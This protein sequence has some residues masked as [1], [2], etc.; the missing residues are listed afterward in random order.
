MG[1]VKLWKRPA[2]GKFAGEAQYPENPGKEGA[3]PQ[4]LL[5][6]FSAASLQRCMC[7]TRESVKHQPS[8]QV[9][10]EACALREG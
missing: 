6:T 3:E 8:R 1:L 9:L 2:C 4:P 7:S 10:E 5:L